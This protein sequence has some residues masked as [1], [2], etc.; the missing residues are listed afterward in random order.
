MTHTPHTTLRVLADY[1]NEEKRWEF[2]AK[3]K[4]G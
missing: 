4:G 1:F 3:G 2:E